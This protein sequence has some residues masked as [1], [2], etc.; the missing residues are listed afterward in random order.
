MKFCSFSKSL[1]E[2]ATFRQAPVSTPILVSMTTRAM[3]FCFS[4]CSVFCFPI[5]TSHCFVTWVCSP[6]VCYVLIS[7]SAYS[8][9]LTCSKPDIKKQPSSDNFPSWSSGLFQI[10]GP[11]GTEHITSS[12]ISRPPAR[13]WTDK[14]ES[15][16][17]SMLMYVRCRTFFMSVAFMLLGSV[18]YG[19]L[20]A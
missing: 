13:K 11:N 3:R 8:L 7:W 16:R 2:R 14:M 20:L 19:P 4:L 17:C 15:K 1:I 18:I 6:V 5:L 9:S 10:C 12:S